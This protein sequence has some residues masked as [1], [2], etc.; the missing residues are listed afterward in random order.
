MATMTRP[1]ESTAAATSGTASPSWLPSTAWLGRILVVLIA[2]TLLLIW[3]LYSATTTDLIMPT[4]VDVA[5]RLWDFVTSA[6]FW[7]H[8][9]VTIQ[10]IAAGFAVGSVIGVGFGVLAAEFMIARWVIMPYVIVVQALP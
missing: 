4:P 10:E 3:A 6:R 9:W 7:P 1:K 2:G 8:F 5:T